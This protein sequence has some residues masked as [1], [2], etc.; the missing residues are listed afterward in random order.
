MDISKLIPIAF[1]HL[2]RILAFC[3]LILLH[4]C[5]D[6]TSSPDSSEQGPFL[7]I[8]SEGGIGGGDLY[9]LDPV[10]GE[11]SGVLDTSADCAGTPCEIGSIRSSA[12]DADSQTLI[13]GT[14][15]DSDFCP[16]CI[17][18]ID[19]TSF[20]GTILW[21]N[22]TLQNAIGT[23]FNVNAVPGISIRSDGTMFAT[24]KQGEGGAVG[25]IR[26]STSSSPTYIGLTGVAQSVSRQYDLGNGLAFSSDGTLYYTTGAGL[27]SIN[28]STAEAT[29][30]G[31]LTYVGITIVPDE[32]FTRVGGLVITPSQQLAG[33]LTHD[34]QRFFGIIDPNDLTFST[35]DFFQGDSIETVYNLNKFTGLGL[36]PE[37]FVTNSIS[38]LN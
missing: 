30:I 25:L 24:L 14:S 21:D 2:I 27:S 32:D 7:L 23:D 16:A 35:T 4:A 26:F 36:I 5:S 34:S 19:L 20:I 33:I 22:A 17:I 31:D 18:Q 10:T 6:S 12:Y 1:T 29:N 37:R 15:N 11:I 3:S 28:T 13:V 8:G 38:P 9:V